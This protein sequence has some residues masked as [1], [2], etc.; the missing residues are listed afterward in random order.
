MFLQK[1]QLV[2]GLPKI[3]SP[4]EVCE[5][6]VVSKKHPKPFPASKSLRAKKVLEMVHSDM[7]GPISPTLN[8]GKSYFISFIDDYS[9]YTWVCFIKEKYEVLETFKMFKVLFENKIGC[10]IKCLHTYQGGEYNSGD[11][12]EFCEKHGIKRKLTADYTPQQNGVCERKK[13]IV[14]DKVC[15]VLKRSGLP[16]DFWANDVHWSIHILNRS[17]TK[18]IRNDAS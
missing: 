13:R 9:R 18:T 16:R 1:K 11:F 3:E 6:C 10:Q 8:G 7:C 2:L 12:V 5:Y 14:L 15:T 4:N 17:P